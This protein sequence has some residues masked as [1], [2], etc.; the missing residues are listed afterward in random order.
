M[1][2]FHTTWPVEGIHTLIINN[3]TATA[4]IT[5]TVIIINIIINVLQDRIG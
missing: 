1:K 5:A 2:N 3:T 4:I